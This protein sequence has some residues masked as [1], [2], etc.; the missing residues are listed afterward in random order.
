MTKKKKLRAPTK[1]VAKKV[2]R[3]ARRSTRRGTGTDLSALEKRLEKAE[4][5]IV[6][7]A[8]T[9]NTYTVRVNEIRSNAG[10]DYIT[11]P[12]ARSVE[13]WW[14]RE[15]RP[16]K[17]A[18][19]FNTFRE[20]S[21]LDNWTSRREKFWLEVEDRVIAAKQH[22]IMMQRLKE[23]D[24]LTEI[25]AP[26]MEYL[27]PLRDHEGR[28]VRH[29]DGELEGLPKYPLALPSMEKF[30]KA[31]IDLD[32]H[33]MLKR[34]EATARS[35][36]LGQEGGG[37]PLDPVKTKASFSRED[38][39]ALSRYLLTMRQPELADAPPIVIHDEVYIGAN[40]DEDDG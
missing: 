14:N 29:D 22:Q 35:E 40:E 13:Y 3:R 18:V 39:R 2:P 24:E 12:D 23:V 38:V 30:I 4:A 20:W 34:G 9:K 26:M 7:P 32:K 1:K 17:R 6:K 21:T 11:D 15:D 5:A 28:I 10:V 27:Q 8:K 25:R 37:N 16:Y 36:Q 31:L 33:L 19:T